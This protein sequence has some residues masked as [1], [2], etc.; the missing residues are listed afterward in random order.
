MMLMDIKNPLP[1]DLDARFYKHVT[2]ATN[3]PR[4]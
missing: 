1:F 2:V 3:F 4:A